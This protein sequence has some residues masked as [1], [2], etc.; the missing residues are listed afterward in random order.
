MD[1]HTNVAHKSGAPVAVSRKQGEEMPSTA[2]ERIAAFA[3]SARPEQMTS[4]V[5]QLYKRNILDSLGC[6]IVALPGAP[7]QAL[8]EQFD[9]YRAPGR[10]TLIGGARPP[11]IRLRS[12]TP[13]S[14]AMPIFSTAICHQAASVTRVTTSAQFSLPLSTQERLARISWSRSRFPM[15]FNAGSPPLSP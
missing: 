9:E 10:C 12:S 11:P 13:A 4:E 7:F 8:R 5:R 1:P 15:K 14:Y 6:A 3:A 2:V